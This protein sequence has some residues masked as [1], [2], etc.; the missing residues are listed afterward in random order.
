VNEVKITKSQ[1]KQIIQEEIEKVT[2]ADDLYLAEMFETSSDDRY[3]PGNRDE[4]SEEKKDDDFLGD[5]KSTGEWTDYTIAQL[6]KKKDTLM[7]KEK[8]TAAEVKT[9][10]QL[11]FAINAKQGDYKKKD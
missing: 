6:Q 2:S 10:R 8:R 5:V 9:V 3:K 4:K 1:L 11:N 7:K